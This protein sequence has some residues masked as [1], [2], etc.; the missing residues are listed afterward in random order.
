MPSVTPGANTSAVEVQGVS[1]RG[2]WL[3]VNDREF[4]L[5]AA[6]FPWFA[7]ARVVDV[8]RVELLHGHVLHWPALDVDL[9]VASLDAP[10]EW[11]LVWRG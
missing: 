3:L 1:P 7:D 8:Y 4:F 10:G 2:L 9:D 5:P 11:P 6:D